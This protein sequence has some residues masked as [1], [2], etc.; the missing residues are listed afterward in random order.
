LRFQAPPLVPGGPPGDSLYQVAFRYRLDPAALAQW[1]GI[2]RDAR[3]IAG[4]PLRLRPPLPGQLHPVHG[5]AV[6]AGVREPAPPAARPRDTARPAPVVTA[7][8]APPVAVASPPPQAP[9]AARPPVASVAGSNTWLWPVDG[10]VIRRFGGDSDGIDVRVDEGS[11]VRA[12]RAGTVVYGGSAL[13]GY[14]LLVILAHENDLMTAYG[15]T[16]E[17]LVGEGDAVRAGQVIAR[18]GRGPG[19]A[20]L[21]HFEVRQSGKPVNPLDWLPTRG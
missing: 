20:P 7:P 9:A 18:S 2:G 6:V 8:P 5:G 11:A 17:L 16:T 10:P 12:A 13:K 4:A 15:H 21:L 19:Q 3:I 14:G 1:N